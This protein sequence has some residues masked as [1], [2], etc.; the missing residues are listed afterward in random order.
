MQV[1][2]AGVISLVAGNG[3]TATLNITNSDG[4]FTLIAITNRGFS[5]AQMC[6]YLYVI[7]VC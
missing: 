1:S 7:W 4:T 5:G 2:A 6:C 3:T